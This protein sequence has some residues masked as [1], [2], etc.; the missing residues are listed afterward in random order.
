MSDYSEAW[1]DL[2]KDRIKL[3][4]KADQCKKVLINEL[5]SDDMIR[6]M[7]A[8]YLKTLSNN[9]IIKLYDN[10]IANDDKL[11]DE[12]HNAAEV[13]IDTLKLKVEMIR[14]LLRFRFTWDEIYQIFRYSEETY[15][16]AIKFLQ[17]NRL[18]DFDTS[19]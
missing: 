13:D 9:Y 10:F 11:T 6:L 4:H 2:N 5:S 15:N 1:E 18:I 12:V 7:F 14:H 17:D 16:D 19:N 8:G 3:E